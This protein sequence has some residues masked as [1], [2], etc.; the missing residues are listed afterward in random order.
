MAFRDKYTDFTFADKKS[1]SYKVW[2]TNKNDIEIALTPSFKDQFTTPQFGGVR[3][4]NGTTV[5][6]TDIKVSCI[7]IDVTLNEWRSICNWLSPFK[8]GKLSF[9]FNKYTY[10]NVKL[11]NSVN[12][13][14][15]NY[16]GKDQL[17][18]GKKIIEF[19][20]TFTTVGDYAA[21]GPFNS[22]L[23]SYERTNTD[24]NNIINELVTRSANHYNIPC[25]YSDVNTIKVGDC[26]T[27][28][29][30]KLESDNYSRLQWK[31]DEDTD[32][33][34]IHQ[35]SYE[36]SNWRYIIFPEGE[37]SST[38]YYYDSIHK[39]NYISV[40][41]Q[42]SN[43]ILAQ[44]SNDSNYTESI[45]IDN[46]GL[47]IFNVGEYEAYPQIHLNHISSGFEVW[48]DDVL[49]YDYT[50][51][52]N[53]W[54]NNI[55]IDCQS[56]VITYNGR[57]VENATDSF[58]YNLINKSINMGPLA[59]QSGNPEIHR[60]KLTGVNGNSLTF[61]LEEP[62]ID[63]SH[64][65]INLGVTITNNILNNIGYGEGNYDSGYYEPHMINIPENSFYQTDIHCY[66]EQNKENSSII[67]INMTPNKISGK[68]NKW[69][70]I[71]HKWEWEPAN[72]NESDDKDKI[73]YI[74]LCKASRLTI[75]SKDGNITDSYVS[76]QSRGAI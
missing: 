48:L 18:G 10:Y 22:G 53:R 13:K 34:I 16:R 60:A 12:G 61:L 62:L 65:S 73:F 1:S 25:I 38:N 49:Y 7:A 69:N 39:D 47:N 57:I 37:D 2:I 9:D 30:I 67:T 4:L 19:S 52:N 11:S 50:F 8:V 36:N 42:K 20:L 55:N 41:Q 43:L 71:E 40:L 58:G 68:F 66:I 70:D 3:Y 64:D 56:G 5:E 76:I 75:K 31:T 33:D 24:I 45:N 27:G 51:N 74:S 59:I 63:I 72:L 21:L 35:L 32:K 15:F 46:T 28:L 29:D 44:T 54:F 17:L 26:V 23:I 14:M 6:K